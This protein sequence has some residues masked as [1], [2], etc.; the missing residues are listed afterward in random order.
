MTN[1]E[2]LQSL[3]DY[4]NSNLFSKVLTDHGITGSATYTSA[5]QESI[6]LALADVYL[7]MASL[8]EYKEGSQSEKY[9]AKT[10]LALRKRLLQK[11]NEEDSNISGVEIW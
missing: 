5:N 8:P 1:L 11:Y 9:D 2:A 7:Y 3:V 10:L 4:S 6:D